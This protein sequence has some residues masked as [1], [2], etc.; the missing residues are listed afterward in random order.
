MKLGFVGLGKMG[1]GMVQRLIRAGHTCVVYDRNKEAVQALL[2][3]GVIEADGL[4]SLVKQLKGPRVVWLMLPAGEATEKVIHELVTHLSLGDC[5]IDG[6]NSYYKDSVRRANELQS[7]GF[8]VLDVGTSGGIWGLREGYTL[9]V[10][11]SKET[12]QRSRALFEA[13]APS[14]DRG[15]AHVGDNG[16][17][18]FAKMIHNGIEYGLMQAYAEG[19]E[20]L[21]KKQ[22]LNFDLQQLAELWC[23]GSV[24]RSWLLELTAKALSEHPSLTGVSS[25]VPDSGEGR[26]TVLEALDLECSI[27]V[28]S[29]SLERRFRSREREPFSDKLLVA[30]RRQF[31]GH[32]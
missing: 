30:L 1:Q 5:I 31:G 27:P 13:L 24:V 19:F 6:G 21:Y 14:H 18:H 32:S 9:M 20:L 8:R 22:E 23:H 15:W 25:Y 10:G 4:E 29:A 11:G 12:V 17:G 26:W 2:Q 3:T 28:I 16:A 7:Q